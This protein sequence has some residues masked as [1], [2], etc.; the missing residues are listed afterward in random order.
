M[1]RVTHTRGNRANAHQHHATVPSIPTSP[2]TDAPETDAAAS[3]NAATT[4]EPPTTTTHAAG[5]AKT[6][7]RAQN[8]THSTGA[9]V[10]LL[11]ATPRAA[12]SSLGP[13]PSAFRLIPAPRTTN[14]SSSV[15]PCSA[16]AA[17][18]LARHTA[19]HAPTLHVL[20]ATQHLAWLAAPA[21][22]PRAR[23]P[24]VSRL[25]PLPARPRG[26][27]CARNPVSA[28]PLIEPPRRLRYRAAQQSGRQ[29]T[30][31]AGSAR[32]PC[33]KSR[34]AGARTSISACWEHT[35]WRECHA[36][37]ESRRVAT[38]ASYR[39]SGGK[40]A[41][42][43]RAEAASFAWTRR[44]PSARV[45]QVLA[46]LRPPARTSQ[47]SRLRYAH[48]RA[49]VVRHLNGQVS[50]WLLGDARGRAR[51]DADTVSYEHGDRATPGTVIRR[52]VTPPAASQQSRTTA[53]SVAI[54]DHSRHKPS[55][56]HFVTAPHGHT[57]APHSSYED[58]TTHR[59][60]LPSPTAATG[61]VPDTSACRA[62]PDHKQI[63]RR[64]R[65][66][67][68]SV[69]AMWA[70]CLW[71]LAPYPKAN[72][73]QMTLNQTHQPH[74]RNHEDSS[75]TARTQRPPRHRR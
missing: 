63:R 69:V 25:T 59:G 29:A 10:A 75:H 54:P 51:A 22:D 1:N 17:Q 58:P 50:R 61:R 12:R 62:R 46:P 34:M 20:S 5:R 45:Q 64:C 55:Q 26:Y 72:T 24:L 11:G 8:P 31:H 57:T 16:A 71:L 74:A 14:R 73:G 70:P 21:T 13:N 28:V 42:S 9:S 52:H 47:L 36:P 4:T 39:S 67:G 7:T 27:R 68:Q 30:N 37:C 2:R 38:P 44:G 56:T 3:P 40:G 35:R 43:V 19:R 15:P 48:Q 41:M 33:S 23:P 49:R 6:P 53:L 66:P 65:A 60:A 32:V 18:T